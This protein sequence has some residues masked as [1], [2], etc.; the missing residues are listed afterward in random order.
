MWG[1]TYVRILRATSSQK[2]LIKKE[3]QEHTN[4]KGYLGNL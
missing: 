2:L 3:R 1:D 4:V